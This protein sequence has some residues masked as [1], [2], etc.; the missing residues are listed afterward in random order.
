MNADY[1]TKVE[2]CKEKTAKA[3]ERASMI[4][5]ATRIQY[6]ESEAKIEG[7]DF[8]H[9]YVRKL[10]PKEWF[11]N[12][13]IL[14]DIFFSQLG[15][16]IAIGE[17]KHLIK[18]I[19]KNA[20]T[21]RE[22]FTWNLDNLQKLVLGFMRTRIARSGFSEPVI[23]IPI[24]KY[25]DVWTW[26]RRNKGFP[27]ESEGK[28]DFLRFGN[29]RIPI[30]WSTK[31]Y[32]FKNVMIVDKSF[33]TWIVKMGNYTKTLSIDIQPDETDKERIDVSVRTVVNYR[34][35]DP[36]AIKLLSPTQKSSTQI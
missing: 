5:G 1:E 17:K 15:E 3:Y 18:Q 9:I 31:Y 19:I 14:P 12:P 34:I 2:R 30:F 8:V 22:A 36:S 24:E 28:Y 27:V 6:V 16:I 23:F 26:R 32:D 11:I 10:V 7:V 4:E 25:V 33:G 20:K 29:M 35:N 21:E 13:A